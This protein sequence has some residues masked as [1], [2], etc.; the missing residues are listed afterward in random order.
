MMKRKILAF[1][2]CSVLSIG[3]Y[4]QEVMTVIT[5]G[6]GKNIESATQRAAEAALTQVVGSFI[7]STK[8][9]EKEKRF[10]MVLKNKLKKLAQK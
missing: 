8:M 1:I 6:M 9:V 4:S 10:A 3:S 2:M 7:D 5:D